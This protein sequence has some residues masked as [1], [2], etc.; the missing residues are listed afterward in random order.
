MF[1]LKKVWRDDSY[2][3]SFSRHY[4][5]EAFYERIYKI[6]PENLGAKVYFIQ[7]LPDVM[8]Y[9]RGQR[10]YCYFMLY[11]ENKV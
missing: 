7:N 5:P 10:I 8:K 11:C 9:Y 1:M 6:I 4:S 3:I 2:K